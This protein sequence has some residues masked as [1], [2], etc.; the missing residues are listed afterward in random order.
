LLTPVTDAFIGVAARHARHLMEKE[1][2][3]ERKVF[4]VPNG[5]DIERFRPVAD[6]HSLRSELGIAETAPVAGIVAA[7]RPE[8]NHPLLLKAATD[9]LRQLPQSVFLIVGDGPERPQLEEL[10]RRFDVTHS[11]RFLGNRTDVPE[12]LSLLN[13]FVLTSH[14][15]ANPVSILEAMSC[16]RA[17]V[18]TDVGSV[19]EVVQHGQTGCLVPP[20]DRGALAEALVALLADPARTAE[21]GRTARDLVVQNWS[22]ERMV[23]GYERLIT[24]IYCRK[25]SGGKTASAAYPTVV[26][27]AAVHHAAPPA[28]TTGSR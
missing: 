11:V 2:F 14:N 10:A 16:E 25:A 24:D 15:E 8:K 12:I 19:G 9:V 28:A 21:M 18:A 23:S 7:L 20:R 22:L 17:V 13:V 5:V 3:P 6:C 4:V 1:R 26:D 27:D